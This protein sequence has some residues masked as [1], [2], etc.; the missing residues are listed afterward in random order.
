MKTCYD[1]KHMK[2]GLGLSRKITMSPLLDVTFIDYT[3]RSARCKQDLILTESGK[4]KVFKD[5]LRHYN[6]E[7]KGFKQAERCPMFFS[8]VD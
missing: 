2:V 8:M 3:K 6:K 1:C 4:T 5:V 7:R